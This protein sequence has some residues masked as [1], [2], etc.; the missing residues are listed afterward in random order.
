MTS[1]DASSP[2]DGD[3]PASAR[4]A[5]L[6]VGALVPV[7]R[8][9][10]SKS[11]LGDALG[12]G[13]REALA[14]EMFDRVVGEVLGGLVRRGEL[15]CVWVVTDGDDV[16]ARALDLGAYAV[17]TEGVRPGRS[18]GA[19]V[20]EGLLLVRAWRASPTREAVPPVDRFER[21]EGVWETPDAA[22]VIMGDL[23]SL[24]ADDVR[25]LVTLLETHD[26]VLAPDAAGT[27]TNALAMRLPP[28]MRTRFC[29]GE[30]L[31]DHLR[32]AN[33]L[34]LRV[35]LCERPGLGFDV[36]QPVDYERL[37]RVF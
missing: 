26:I 6:R 32:D 27:G 20:D 3:G 36:D 13:A 17:V 35:A 25:A 1:R 12:P 15:D 23:P 19:I 31:A 5:R 9:D 22:L 21:D 29:G 14:R 34:G 11:R 16:R 28:P 7:K 18:L 10:R 24:E 30:S 37:R 4:A 33:A 8:F 2:E